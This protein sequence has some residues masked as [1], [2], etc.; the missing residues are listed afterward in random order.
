[1]AS[2][3]FYYNEYDNLLMFWVKYLIILQF[4]LIYICDVELINWKYQ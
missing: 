4:V 1:M 3:I 2:W